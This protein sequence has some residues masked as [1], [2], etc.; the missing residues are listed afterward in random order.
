MYVIANSRWNYAKKSKEN[1][2][3]LSRLIV[4]TLLYIFNIC[5]IYF[6]KKRDTSMLMYKLT[7]N[8]LQIN[9][10]FQLIKLAIKF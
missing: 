1:K 8:K 10:Y 7:W 6:F 9:F 3:K 4:N 5:T 2:E